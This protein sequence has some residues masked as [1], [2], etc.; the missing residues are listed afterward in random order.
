MR[1]LIQSAIVAA[2]GLALPL[3]AQAPPAGIPVLDETIDVRVVNVEAVITDASGQRVRGLSVGDF[4]LLVDGQEVP[5]EYFTE[6]EEGRSVGTDQAAA[7]DAAPKTP[8]STGDEVGRS[9]LIYVDDSFSLLDR[10][11]DLLAKLERD[12][13][14][15]RPADQMAVLA[16]DGSHVDLLCGWTGEVGKLRNAFERAR[17]R[18][19]QGGQMLAYQR[20]LQVDVDWVDTHANS[21]DTGESNRVGGPKVHEVEQIQ[22]E[23]A[24]R[25]SPEARTQLGKTAASAAAA[26]RGFETPP[27]RK[28]L[29][30]LSGAWSLS[31]DPYLY[32]PFVEAANRLGYT[33]YP[34]DA[35]QSDATEVTMLDRLARMT[36]GRVVVSAANDAFREVVADS[37]SYYWLGFTPFWR[38]DDLTHKV[39]VEVRRPDLTVRSRIGFTDPSRSIE[40]ARKAE[41]VLLFGGAKEQQRLIVQLGEPRR[42]GRVLELPVTLGVPVEALALRPE[43]TGYR[44]D[45]PLAV[46][47]EDKTGRRYDPPA[48]LLQVALKTLPQAGTYAR[49]QAVFDVRDIEQRLV[50]TVKDPASGQTLWGQADLVPGRPGR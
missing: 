7:P 46:A 32:G 21:I 10:R 22:N 3:T 8:V 49:F 26:L 36:G 5:V 41:S 29:L 37:G 13:T 20:A 33:V 34:V 2:F 4:R 15:L 43:G 16:F 44:A 45:V 1:L 28:V 24:K 27:G 35:S 14:L 31:V 18:P 6:V 39:T 40:N 23:F 19:A 47:V 48:M 17:Q 25:I 50:F 38:A 9:Y 12:L 30:L 11:N 42:K